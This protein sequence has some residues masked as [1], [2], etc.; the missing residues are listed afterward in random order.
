MVDLW[1]NPSGLT[2]RYLNQPIQPNPSVRATGWCSRIYRVIPLKAAKSQYQ[3]RINKITGNGTNC[4]VMDKSKSMVCILTVE[5]QISM[6][7]DLL[8]KSQL[9]VRIEMCRK[10]WGIKRTQ[11]KSHDVSIIIPTHGV[12]VLEKNS[13]RYRT[14]KECRKIDDINNSLETVKIITE[15]GKNIVFICIYIYTYI[16]C[17][18]WKTLLIWIHTHKHNRTA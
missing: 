10:H 17:M 6:V 7:W 9:N 18:F 3:V 2:I 16:K 15:T 14:L 8:F 4:W 1:F 5:I 11:I 13:E 12:I